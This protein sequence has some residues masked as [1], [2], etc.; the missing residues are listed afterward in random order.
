M[1]ALVSGIFSIITLRI[2]HK[3]QQETI[4]NSKDKAIAE[5]IRILLY[6]RIKHLANSYIQKGYITTEQLED[7]I[8]MHKVYHDKDKLDG[9]GFLDSLMKQAKRLPIHN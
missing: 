2:Q 7:L 5:G 6:D 9:N 4:Q 3:M 8:S 1:A